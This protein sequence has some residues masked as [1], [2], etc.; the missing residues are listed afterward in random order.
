MEGYI[1]V[2]HVINYE[3]EDDKYIYKIGRTSDWDNRKNSYIT[4]YEED[5]IIDYISNLLPNMINVEKRIH[6]RLDIYRK[7]KR[8]EFF[9]ANINEIKEVINEEINKSYFE[10][11]PF[12]MNNEYNIQISIDNE[13][14]KYL[15]NNDQKIDIIDKY[16][17]LNK[18]LKNNIDHEFFLRKYDIL[19]NIIVIENNIENK[20]NIQDDIYDINDKFSYLNRKKVIIR[21][22]KDHNIDISSKII[23]KLKLDKNNLDDFEKQLINNLDMYIYHLNLKYLYINNDKN[24]FNINMVYNDSYN[25]YF[26]KL[27]NRYK[28]IKTIH[29]I[30]TILNIN[31]LDDINYELYKNYHNKIEDKDLENNIFNIKKLFNIRSKISNFNINFGY[32]EL[33]L[34]LKTMIAQI[35]PEI[36]EKVKKP[37][38][39]KIIYDGEI[40][41]AIIFKLDEKLIN[42]HKKYF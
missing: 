21:K 24:N 23:N 16:N 32:Y 11:L 27:H 4:C 37:K 29:N 17:L 42:Y 7:N 33:I 9:R 34:L 25:I 38:Q 3:Y 30:L 22:I 13:C 8:R 40:R 19:S 26:D 5:I 6:E 2:F 15:Y 18:M 20:K 14:N 28:K 36:F 35:Y 41:Y 1:Y 39:K 10:I 31:N 12:D